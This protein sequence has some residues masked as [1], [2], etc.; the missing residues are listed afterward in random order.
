[1]P[2]RLAVLVSGEGT[3]L[4]AILDAS[5]DPA[6]GG[7]VVAVV[8]DRADTGA[9]ARAKRS[10]LRAQVVALGDHPDRASWDTALTATVARYKPDL[11]ICAGFMKL[12]APSFLEAFDGHVLN[13]H[14]SLLPKYPGAHAVRD[15][16]AAG[17]AEGG[18][19]VMWVDDGVDTGPVIAQ[20]VVPV[21]DGDDEA[22]LHAR[23]KAAEA[24]L[25][26]ETI[27]RLIQEKFA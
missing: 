3:T 5:R 15:T 1:V 17:E 4:Q 2:A 6:F 24:P 19:T 11:V 7:T 25:Y 14:P 27:R 12:L 16:I 13:T 18:A 20:V 8:S 10:G 9:E 23:I 22:H 21:Q 26:V